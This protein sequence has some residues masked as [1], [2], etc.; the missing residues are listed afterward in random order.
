MAEQ[1]KERILHFPPELEKFI[2]LKAA[3]ELVNPKSKDLNYGAIPQVPDGTQ[4]NGVELQAINKLLDDVPALLKKQIL[5][6]FQIASKYQVLNNY[7]L[8]PTSELK[9]NYLSIAVGIARAVT[10]ND[11]MIRQ[12]LD[13]KGY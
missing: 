13:K 1:M 5:G 3:N 11:R 2:R 9:K 8:H 6:N 7:I 12:L 4:I 10:E